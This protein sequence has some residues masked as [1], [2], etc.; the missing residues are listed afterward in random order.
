MGV[1]NVE[2]K[3]KVAVVMGSDSD[4]SVLQNCIKVLKQFDVEVSAIV[5]SAHRTPDKAAEFAKGA[6]ETVLML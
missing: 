2:K 6:E 3:P 1:T 4:F 5:C